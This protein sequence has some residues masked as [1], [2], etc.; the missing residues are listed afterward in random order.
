MRAYELIFVIHPDLDE[1]AVKELVERVKNWI[2]EAGGQVSKVDNWGKRKLAYPLRKQAEGQ[3]I[4]MKT[5]MAPS[6]CPQ[7]E[8]NLRLQESVMRFLLALE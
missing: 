2:T 8:R 7:L 3:Y 4:L 6:F 5:Q 1:S